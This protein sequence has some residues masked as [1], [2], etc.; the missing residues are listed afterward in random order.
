VQDFYRPE[1]GAES[2]QK[3]LP[4]PTVSLTPAVEARLVV[5]HSVVGNS[6]ASP[7]RRRSVCRR[8]FRLAAIRLPIVRRRIVK[9]ARSRLR[10][11]MW[12]KPKKLKV[13]GFP[14]PRFLRRSAAYRRNS[15]RQVYP[16]VIPVR[17]S[18][19]VPATAPGIAR[20]HFGA[21]IPAQPHAGRF[22]LP[23]P[24]SPTV[25]ASR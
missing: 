20:P 6:P 7:S 14:S 21:E 2:F 13:S 22:C 19:S 4:C 12:V 10:P 8:L 15:I 24:R 23:A 1:D 25:V 18:V 5:R 3:A 11:Q 16:G 9:Y 17:T